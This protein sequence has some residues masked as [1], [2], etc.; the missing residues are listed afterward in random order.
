MADASSVTRLSN[1]NGTLTNSAAY[2]AFWRRLFG[3][4][5]VP[6]GSKFYGETDGMYAGMIT[7]ELAPPPTPEPSCS[8]SA[9]SV[10]STFSGASCP[11]QRSGGY[12]EPQHLAPQRCESVRRMFRM[13]YRHH[14][15]VTAP[16]G[17]PES[18]THGPQLSAAS[19]L[20]PPDPK[21]TPKETHQRRRLYN[22]DRSRRE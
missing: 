12:A 9:F 8:A 22:P 13:S 1:P 7:A 11:K 19:L 14:H 16:P 5:H 18:T 17:D 21:P 4:I 15:R 3:G 6:S 20:P 2:L 10:L